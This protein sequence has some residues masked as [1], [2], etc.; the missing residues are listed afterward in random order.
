MQQWKRIALTMI[1]SIAPAGLPAANSPCV[2]A[3]VE[4][5]GTVWSLDRK[6]REALRAMAGNPASHEAFRRLFTS[7][8]SDGVPSLPFRRAVLAFIRQDFAE[9]CE[10]DETRLEKAGRH[11]NVDVAVIGLGY[12]AAAFNASL[13]QALQASGEK[14]SSLTISESREVAPVFSGIG[15]V[16]SLNSG[17]TEVAEW[18]PMPGGPVSIPDLFETPDFPAAQAAADAALL[19]QYFAVGEAVVG[20]RVVRLRRTVPG[21]LRRYTLETNRGLVIQADKVVIATGIGTTLLPSADV[22]AARAQARHDAEPGEH[23]A[24]ETVEDFLAAANAHRMTN[25]NPLAPYDGKDI[26]IV[27]AGDG[28]NSVA[29]L[30]AG[31][32]PGGRLAYGP[33]PFE[34][35]AA[36]IG[37]WIWAGQKARNELEFLG[38]LR[39]GAAPNA[40]GRSRS[41]RYERLA[42]L[43]HEHRFAATA[44]KIESVD[45]LP[46]GRVVAW[47]HENGA[48]VKLPPV[49]YVIFAT[50]RRPPLGAVIGRAEP[51]FA[52]VD[53]AETGKT[54]AREVLSL[55]GQT[56]GGIFFIGN[57]AGS[58][59]TREELANSRTHNG[60]SIEVSAPR[61]A[62]F[63]KWLA[64][65]VGRP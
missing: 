48:V 52:D 22:R 59:A 60:L 57:A 54:I 49:H 20:H 13:S 12:H 64:G 33:F 36:R 18:N 53:D 24:V 65:L 37:R 61:T 19:A 21:A 41:S 35:N 63:A 26:L 1:L 38:N 25:K 50:G 62:A 51:T 15:H 39:K 27:G 29:E 34:N 47:G 17:N 42:R 40:G 28:A 5:P 44:L 56:A 30:L 11:A 31:Q 43:F 45:L 9:R 3:L 58:L 55:D 2:E 10:R 14:L 4:K 6:S 16:F 23:A 7:R 8:D 32:M 46:D